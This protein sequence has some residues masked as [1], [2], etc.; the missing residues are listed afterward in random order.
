[1]LTGTPSRDNEPTVLRRSPVL[2]RACGTRRWLWG[3]V[4]GIYAM[5]DQVL[6][7][8]PTLCMLARVTGRGRANSGIERGEW[9]SVSGV[10][11]G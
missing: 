4:A 11:R 7:L 5:R 6:R 2:V 10:R 1:M 8:A 3:V 9:N